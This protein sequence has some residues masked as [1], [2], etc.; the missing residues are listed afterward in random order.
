MRRELAGLAAALCFATGTAAA[1]PAAVELRAIPYPDLNGLEAVVAEELAEA[2]RRIEAALPDASLGS[3]E[4][5]AI[6]GEGGRLYHAYRLFDAAAACY[7]NAARLVPGAFAWLYL[8][9]VVAQERGDLPAARRGYEAAARLAPED[10]AVQVRLGEVLRLAGVTDQA[11]RAFRRAL[12]LAPADAA[13][14]A[15]LGEAALAEGR[16]EAARDAFERALAAA[17]QA[18]SL[19]YRLGLAYRGLGDLERARAELGQRGTIGVKP[20][21]PLVEALEALKSGERVHSIRGR[22]AFG[23]GDLR[24]AVAE[25]RLALAAAPASLPALINLGTALG[26]LSETGEAVELMRRAVE[27]APEHGNARFNLGNLLLQAGEAGEAAEHLSAAARLLPGDA[28]VALLLAR[29]L[30][31]LDACAEAAAWQRRALE[32]SAG[33]SAVTIEA[34]RATLTRYETERPCRTP[35]DIPAF[36]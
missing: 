29:A 18:T 28:E 23:A 30:A 16:F 3:A 19:H 1:Q 2:R 25:F 9:A 15:G 8:A 11:E 31:M 34:L 24:A 32:L 36:D 10:L 27:L 21:D 6:L 22:R 7:D 13:A 26:A 14:L 35:G 4:L 20:P 5:A 12:D 33:A 17:P